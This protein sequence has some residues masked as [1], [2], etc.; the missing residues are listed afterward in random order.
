MLGPA[1]KLTLAVL[2]SIAWLAFA[3]SVVRCVV[4]VPA[5]VLALMLYH[6]NDDDD[7]DFLAL[8]NDEDEL[9]DADTLHGHY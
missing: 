1:L 9:S 2:L 8:P 6:A 3:F 7:E 5:S 4:L